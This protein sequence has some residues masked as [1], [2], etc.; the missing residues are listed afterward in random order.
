MIH[1]L[2]ADV[3]VFLRESAPYRAMAYRFWSAFFLGRIER[4]LPAW[5]AQSG[6]VARV[7]AALLG[8]EAPSADFLEGV[9]ETTLARAF[10]TLFYGVGVETI[11]LTKSAW[12]GTDGLT[13]GRASERARAV[14]RAHGLEVRE[15]GEY[16][17]HLL[18]DHLGIVL[19]FLGDLADRAGAETDSEDTAGA[20][21]AEKLLAHEH[22]F[23]MEFILTWWKGARAV[24]AERADAVP[25]AAVFEAFDAYL[26]GVE[27]VFAEAGV[28]AENEPAGSVAP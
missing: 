25:V 21:D 26:R 15:E 10:A 28:G 9:D 11:P 22:A 13:A 8:E 27:T 16:A 20:L 18:E 5:H 24:L 19:G 23:L 17:E 14:Y 2:Q 4:D 6:D 1:D 12:T 7:T 3:R